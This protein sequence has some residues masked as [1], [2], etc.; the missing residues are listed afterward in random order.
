MLNFLVQAEKGDRFNFLIILILKKDR[1]LP[2][3]IRGRVHRCMG[4][5]DTKKNIFKCVSVRPA[6][7]AEQQT[8][9]EFVRI[10]DVE[11]AEYVKTM[12]EV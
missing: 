9:H 10:A 11:M 5:Y 4:N 2:R 7:L 3:L 12:N 6:T 1:E 8:F